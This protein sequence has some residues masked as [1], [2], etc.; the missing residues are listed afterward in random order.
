MGKR[1]FGAV[2]NKRCAQEVRTDG[3]DARR[4]SF[5]A[6]NGWRTPTGD[7]RLH[8]RREQEARGPCSRACSQGSRSPE[9]EPLIQGEGV[10]SEDRT[11]DAQHLAI[12]AGAVRAAHH[13]RAGDLGSDASAAPR[14]GWRRASRSA[15]RCQAIAR[16]GRRRRRRRDWGRRRRRRWR[17]HRVPPVLPRLTCP[18]GVQRGGCA[19]VHAQRAAALGD[20]GVP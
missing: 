7:R 10:G 20:H 2:R 11:A 13:V 1:R 15:F 12:G 3:S 18:A 8:G 19:R 6:R 14:R 4:G 17:E 9:H 16:C 5:G